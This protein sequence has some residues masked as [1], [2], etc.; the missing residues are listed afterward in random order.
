MGRN[1]RTHVTARPTWPKPANRH[2]ESK[3][4]VFMLNSILPKLSLAKWNFRTAFEATFAAARIECAVK[5][6][7]EMP[8]APLVTFAEMVDGESDGW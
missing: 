1:A 6:A 3:P 5:F 8:N 2:L 7:R 4:M